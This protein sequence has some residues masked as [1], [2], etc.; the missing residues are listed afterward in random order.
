MIEYELHQQRGRELQQQALHHHLANEAAR[1]GEPR[2]GALRRFAHSLRHGITTVP[3]R[4]AG[5][6]GY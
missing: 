2:V 4:T 5:P 6:A 3:L 1:A